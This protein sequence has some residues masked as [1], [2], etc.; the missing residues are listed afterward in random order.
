MRFGNENMSYKSLLLGSALTLAFA[1]QSSA[2]VLSND[3]VDEVITTALRA[4]TLDDV[5]S[6]VS[7]LNAQDLAIRNPAYLVDQLRAVPGVGISRSGSVGALTQVRLRGAEANHTLVLVNGI[8]ASDPV[9]GETDFSLWSG[10]NTSR[11]EVARGEQSVLYGSDAIGGVVSVTTRDEGLYGAAEYGSFNT[12]RAQLGFGA[13]S[14]AFSYGVS[15]GVFKTDGVDTSG[16]NGGKDGS[17]SYAISAQGSVALSPD[18]SANG[19]SSFRRSNA[20][21]D[22]DT[23]FDGLLNDVDRQTEAD[24]WILGAAIIGRTGALDHVIRANISEVVRDNSAART[25]TDQTTGQRTK[26]TYS[27][28]ITLGEDGADVTISGIADWEGEDYERVDTNTVFGDPNQA[29]SFNTYGIGGEARARVGAIIVNGSI[30]FDDNDGQFEDATTWRLGTAYNFNFGGKLRASAG[31]GVKNPTF[32][33]LF[34]FFPNSFIGNPDLVPEKSESWEIG[35]DHNF[36]NFNASVTYFDAALED[37]IFTAFTPNFQSTAANREGN[38]SRSGIEVAANWKLSKDTSISGAFSK[39]D[40]QNDT[41]DKEIRVPEWTASAAINWQS[42]STDGFRI[43][44]ALDFVGAQDD[45]NFGTFP[46]SRKKLGS[47]ALL[48]ATAEYPLSDRV[49]VTLR[50]E[51]LLDEGVQDLFGYNGTGAGVFAGF[52]LR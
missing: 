15:A 25:F 34:G 28:S 7:V 6:S 38:S 16:L 31:A 27:P 20:D 30:R 36:G 41:N 33:E 24:Q 18:W 22:A 39:I 42:Q 2:Q 23:D 46:A 43:G 14:E 8:E 21:F 17:Q 47:Y 10:V 12:Q 40:S 52:K 35:Y 4:I 13:Q 51:N 3:K 29:Q 49:S 9:T 44:A 50:G 45:F 5:T 11:I 32:T 19:F 1:A 37:E 26:L 48:S